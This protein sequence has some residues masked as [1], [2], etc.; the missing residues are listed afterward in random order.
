MAGREYLIFL[1]LP[2]GRGSFYVR[3]VEIWGVERPKTQKSY[4]FFLKKG[5]IPLTALL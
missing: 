4:K 2:S 3:E 1:P 5:V